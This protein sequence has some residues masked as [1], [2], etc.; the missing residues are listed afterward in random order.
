M[1]RT[2]TV[3]A[4]PEREAIDRALVTGGAARGLSAI[5]GVS[6]HALARH[7]ENHLADALVRAQDAAEVARGDDLLDQVQQLL[8]WAKSITGEA[9][10]AKDLKTAL[11]G[12]REARGCIELLAE[13]TGS[14]RRKGRSTS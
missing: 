10:K 12:I 6:E 5:Y 13:L 4:H 2:C 3:C 14:C 1:P 7:R 8:R 9:G 11:A